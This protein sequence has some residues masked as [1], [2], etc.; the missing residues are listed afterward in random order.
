M[1]RKASTAAFNLH[2]GHM[3]ANK[4]YEGILLILCYFT[5]LVRLSKFT[6]S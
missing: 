1:G 3:K 5:F 2:G 6:Y 4:L